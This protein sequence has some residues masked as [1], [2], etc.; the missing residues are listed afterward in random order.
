MKSGGISSWKRSLIELTKIIAGVAP[1]QRDLERVRVQGQAESGT[2]RAG[3]PSRWYLAWPMRLRR[4][5]KVEC[6]A[7]RAA[8][9]YA[10]ATGNGVP[11]RL[12]PLDRAAASHSLI[13]AARIGSP[14]V[15]VRSPRTYVR[16]TIGHQN[17]GRSSL[18]DR[19]GLWIYWRTA[20][21]SWSLRQLPAETGNEVVIRRSLKGGKPTSWPH[22]LS[23]MAGKD[24]WIRRINWTL[25][26]T[27]VGSIAAVAA[28]LLAS[29]SPLRPTQVAKMIRQAKALPRA[30]AAYVKKPKPMPTKRVKSSRE[31]RNFPHCRHELHARWLP[32]RTVRRVLRW[33][34]SGNSYFR[35]NPLSKLK[36]GLCPILG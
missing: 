2:A 16:I 26:W 18:E 30:R 7:V 3:A 17:A 9:R 25:L 14:C 27:A 5:A 13:F 29:A 31:R 12:G 23:P 19:S 15:F 33:L 34:Y 21:A 8:G 4:A 20:M 28:V 24:N 1:P 11:G 36:T 32:N 6:V 22:R 10:V 35:R